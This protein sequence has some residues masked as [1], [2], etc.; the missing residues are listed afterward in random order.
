MVQMFLIDNFLVVMVL[1]GQLENRDLAMIR[2][3]SRAAKCLHGK[4]MAGL[5]KKSGRKC[6]VLPNQ[7]LFED[8]FTANM[9]SCV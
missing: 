5:G 8:I 2:T 3:E 6:T 1:I 7:A 4:K 9:K